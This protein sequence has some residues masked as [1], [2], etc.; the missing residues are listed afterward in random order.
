M[1]GDIS[2]KRC[3]RELRENSIKDPREKRAPKTKA[4]TKQ[5]HLDAGRN[6][7]HNNE[8]RPQNT[9]KKRA[10]EEKEKLPYA[11]SSLDAGTRKT[12]KQNGNADGIPS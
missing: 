4:A 11:F 10:K 9:T 1:N 7:C 8:L 5:A 12:Q 3:H 6:F 2:L